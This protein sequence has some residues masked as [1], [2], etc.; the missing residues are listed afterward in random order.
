M[1]NLNNK[2]YQTEFED[3]NTEQG[4][5][6]LPELEVYGETGFELLPE[7]EFGNP[8]QEYNEA[9]LVQ[10]LQEI[11]NE[12]EFG[13]WLKKLAKMGGST[14]VRLL[15]SAT[16]NK[17]SGTLSSIAKRTLPSLAANAGGIAASALQTAAGR[18]PDFVKFAS[19]AIQ[20]VAKEVNAG[21]P[22]PDI[23]SAIIKAAAKHYPMILRSK[24]GLHANNVFGKK[25][26]EFEYNNEYANGSNQELYGEIS[27]AEGSF[28]EVTEMELASELLNV[29]SEAELDQFLGGLFKKAVG[30]VSKF[31]R[32][33]T[34]KALGGMLKGIAKKALPIAGG[35]LGTFIAPGLGT[36]IGGALGS[37]AGN[38][39]ELEMEGLSAEDREFEVAR[40]FVRFAGNAAKK[41]SG[42]SGRNPAYSARQAIINSARRYAPGLLVNNIHTHVQES[43]NGT[44]YRDGNRIVLEGI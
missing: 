17:V 43:D 18:Y 19:G 31:A 30:A 9:E 14:A 24:G 13:K 32:S 33:S 16:G 34:G 38:L 23:R 44:W 6:L 42:M 4:F 37:A 21:N 2:Y 20:D 22:L 39:F 7:F 5:E 8:Q 27:S 40:A 10:E 35:A 41:A 36:A 26:N 28:N 11:T 25:N 12:A 29:Q 15:N 1:H 3:M